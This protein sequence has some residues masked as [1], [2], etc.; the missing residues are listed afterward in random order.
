MVPVTVHGGLS[1]F[2]RRGGLGV[3]GNTLFAANMG[4]SP[5]AQA[6]RHIFSAVCRWRR[7]KP[8]G[9]KNKPVPRA[10]EQLQGSRR[11]QGFFPAA[12]PQRTRNGNN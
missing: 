8:K 6:E 2:S 3:L 10:C 5:S 11:F 12:S 7:E 9:P 4:L 1:Q